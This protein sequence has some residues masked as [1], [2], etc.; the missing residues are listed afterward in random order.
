[1]IELNEV[2]R[3]CKAVTNQVNNPDYQGLTLEQIMWEH[4]YAKELRQDLDAYYTSKGWNVWKGLSD[5][6]YRNVEPMDFDELK[7]QSRTQ[8]NARALMKLDDMLRGTIYELSNAYGQFQGIIEA[9]QRHAAAVLVESF[10][11]RYVEPNN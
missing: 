8:Q 5:L 9:S 11:S 1:M 6:D 10:A 7:T 3:L 4:G 2:Y